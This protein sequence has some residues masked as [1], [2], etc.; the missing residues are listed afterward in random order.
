MAGFTENLNSVPYISPGP[1]SGSLSQVRDF[2]G[3]MIY[4]ESLISETAYNRKLKHGSKKAI[5]IST[6]LRWLLT[7]R[8]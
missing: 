7:E 8:K 5:R 1:R 6:L 4:A 2:S 3:L